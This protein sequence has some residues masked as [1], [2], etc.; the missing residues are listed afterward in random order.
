MPRSKPNETVVHRV[1]LGTWE[2]NH[3]EGLLASRAWANA[4]GPIVDLLTSKVAMGA[5]LVGLV[6]GLIPGLPGDWMEQTE[7]MSIAQVKDWLEPQNLLALGG[8]ILAGGILGLGS[9]P[10]LVI[11]LL[12]FA[13]V[14]ASEDVIE[15]ATDP[16]GA[17]KDARLGLAATLMVATTT[18]RNL[19]DALS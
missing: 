17:S 8:G 11:G 16:G 13:G 6:T 12:A 1:E 18:Y 10:A 19:I 4:V 2:R 14:E 5:I 3:L 15:W 9:L 7:G